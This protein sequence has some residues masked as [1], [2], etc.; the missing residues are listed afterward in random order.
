M[1]SKSPFL[2]QTQ[3]FQE[4]KVAWI[5]SPSHDT[6]MLQ[7]RRLIIF[8]KEIWLESENISCY[9]HPNPFLEKI[10]GGSKVKRTWASVPVC[11]AESWWSLQRRWTRGNGFILPWL[12]FFVAMWE[13]LPLIVF[14]MVLLSDS[15]LLCANKNSLLIWLTFLCLRHF[16]SKWLGIPT[17]MALKSL[18]SCKCLKYI[19]LGDYSFIREKAIKLDPGNY[20]SH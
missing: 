19:G 10:R 2:S 16:I 12:I 7:P 17:V 14:I 8:Q 3:P 13:M 4:R 15:A 11:H 1:L 9:T 5:P 6:E 20:L 18:K